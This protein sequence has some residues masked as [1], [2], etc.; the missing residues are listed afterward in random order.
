MGGPGTDMIE[1]MRAAGKEVPP[2]MQAMADALDK[3]S[4]A[5]AD[6]TVRLQLM[7]MH[8]HKGSR[9]L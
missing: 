4:A 3:F 8:M 7:A 5:D 1:S 6:G 2:S 9:C